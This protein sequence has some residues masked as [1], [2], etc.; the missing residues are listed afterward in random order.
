MKA[1]AWKAPLGAVLGLGLGL[2][3]GKLGGER[4]KADAG[5]PIL[6]P[7]PELPWSRPPV[8]PA[9]LRSPSWETTL[10][11]WRTATTAYAMDEV[12]R[13]AQSFLQVAAAL[14]PKTSSVAVSAFRTTRC[15]ALDNYAASVSV[16]EPDPET[17]LLSLAQANPDCRH[18]LTLRASRAS[19][20]KAARSSTLSLGS[21]PVDTK[22]PNSE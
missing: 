9:R 19:Q 10:D 22:A 20:L 12:E 3:C 16:L 14:K 18:S 4:Q 15:L 17:H 7:I 2:S 8:L 1:K 6:G 11:T 13:A 21:T 5:R